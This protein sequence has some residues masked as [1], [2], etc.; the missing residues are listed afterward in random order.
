ML[1]TIFI[2][3][4]PLTKTFNVNI[5]WFEY[6]KIRCFVCVFTPAFP[7]FYCWLLLQFF[8]L[9]QIQKELSKSGK[10][11]SGDFL[12]F[13]FCTQLD[14]KKAR[15]FISFRHFA[16][17]SALIIITV[18]TQT[19]DKSIYHFNKMFYL[20]WKT[21]FSTNSTFGINMAF[22]WI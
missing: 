16:P 9:K 14:W 10:R 21:Q 15:I 18:K 12:A 6:R 3:I 1:K 22:V 19:D 13:D 17:I 2:F 8:S 4:F 5:F 20:K 7:Y 11:K